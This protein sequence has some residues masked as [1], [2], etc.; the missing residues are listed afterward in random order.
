MSKFNACSEGHFNFIEIN[1]RHAKKFNNLVAAFNIVNSIS[2]IKHLQKSL[3]FIRTSDT[4]DKFSMPA[5]ALELPTPVSTMTTIDDNVVCID[6]VE[7]SSNFLY[8]RL[9]QMSLV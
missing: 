6:D 2:D 5:S 4:I 8:P 1:S 3:I 9:S 7:A